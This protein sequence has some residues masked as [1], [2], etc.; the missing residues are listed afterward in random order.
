MADVRFLILVGPPSLDP[1]RMG[2]PPPQ[3]PDPAALV[4]TA[5]SADVARMRGR[6]AGVR[7]RPEP[8]AGWYAWRLMAS[9]NRRLARSVTSFATRPGTVEA[10]TRLTSA[11]ERLQPYVVTEPRNGGWGWRAELDGVA[12]AACPHWYERERDCRTGFRRFVDAALRAHVA[13]GGTVLRDGRAPVLSSFN[14]ERRGRWP[15]N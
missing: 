8:S 14:P 9:N 6:R 5:A 13:E 3:P 10:I 2:F 12:V 7:R 4:E 15:A 1:S 11:L